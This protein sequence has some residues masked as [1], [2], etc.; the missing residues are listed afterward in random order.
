MKDDDDLARL[1]VT[2]AG[3]TNNEEVRTRA[4]VSDGV[5]P[6]VDSAVVR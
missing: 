3:M 5:H 4:W 2:T 1:V 6:Y